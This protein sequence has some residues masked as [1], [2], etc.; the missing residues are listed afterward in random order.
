MSREP[1]G[2]VLG[3]ALTK[4]FCISDSAEDTESMLIGIENSRLRPEMKE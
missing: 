2:S 4:Q 3:P 1:W